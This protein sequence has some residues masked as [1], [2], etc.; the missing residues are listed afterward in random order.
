MGGDPEELFKR[1]ERRLQKQV[2]S[3]RER[4]GDLVPVTTFDKILNNG[5][6]FPEALAERVRRR[7]VVVVRDT[8]PEEEVEQM[9]GD[10]LKYMYDNSAFPPHG[11][12]Q[13]RLRMQTDN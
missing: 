7:G 10:L 9:V 8:I 6:R 12:N 13:V 2:E 5:G 11:K 3:L 1:V 4:G